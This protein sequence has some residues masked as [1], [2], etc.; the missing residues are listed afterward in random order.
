MDHE[1]WMLKALA[2][3]DSRRGFCAP[4]PAVGAVIVSSTGELV[5]TGCHFAS[6]YAHAEVDALQ[7]AQSQSRGSTLYV[8]LEPCNH[9]GKTPPC[10]QAIIDAGIQCVYYG[11]SDPNPHVRGSGAKAL[12][13]A[14]ISCERIKTE[15]VSYFY[16]SYTHWLK[17]GSARLIAKLAQTRDGMTAK[18]NGRP[19][20]ITGKEAEAYTA[21]G[22]RLADVILTTVKTVLNDDPSLN[23][24]FMDRI[25]SRAVYVLDSKLQFP[26]NAKLLQTAKEVILLYKKSLPVCEKKWPANELRCVSVAVDGDR[27]SW[28]AIAKLLGQAGFHEVWVEVGPSAFQSLLDSGQLSEAVIYESNQIVGEG[29][30]GIRLSQPIFTEAKCLEKKL[31]DDTVYLFSWS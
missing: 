22:R 28:K 3:A 2:A 31:G 12:Q 7:K 4:N 15:E 9:V 10:T 24:R 19:L 13:K 23:C 30:F 6:G 25:E 5:A 1:K 26:K 11:Y 27:F 17:T 21:N 8:T 20:A 18:R 14:G 29:L 16:L